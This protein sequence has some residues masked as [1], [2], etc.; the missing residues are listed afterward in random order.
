MSSEL[1][2]P[3]KYLK[4]RSNPKRYLLF[5]FY[6]LPTIL[7]YFTA[8][9]LVFWI[10]GQCTLP[11]GRDGECTAGWS[12]IF[13]G[14]ILFIETLV[15]WLVVFGGVIH[16]VISVI[17]S[18]NTA[19]TKLLIISVGILASVSLCFGGFFVYEHLQLLLR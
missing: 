10:N 18:Q 7:I 5:L 4:V 15:G 16:L 14:P 6:L 2:V 13:W 8:Y 19:V 1:N 9:A 17:K 11:E 3:D 12:I